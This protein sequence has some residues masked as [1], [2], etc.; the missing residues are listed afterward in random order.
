MTFFTSYE[1]S[2]NASSAESLNAKKKGFPAQPRGL[3]G[4]P[5][6]MLRQF[7]IFGLCDTDDCR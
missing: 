2:M 6:F 7:M 1:R 5:F 4:L 3:S